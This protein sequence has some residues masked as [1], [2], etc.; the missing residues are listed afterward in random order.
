MKR[1]ADELPPGL[2][3]SLLAS[4][5]TSAPPEASRTAARRAALA[6]L[7]AELPAL[8]ASTAAVRGGAAAKAGGVSAGWKMLALGVVGGAIATGGGM[9]IVGAPDARRVPSA[10][11]TTA[12]PRTASAP[13]VSSRERTEPVALNAPS[14]GASRPGVAGDQPPRLAVPSSEPPRAE[15][16]RTEA[17][18]SASARPV[19]E[20]LLD[21]RET[22]ASETH[23]T[24]ARGAPPRAVAPSADLAAELDALDAVRRALGRNEPRSALRA[25]IE[26]DQ[27]FPSGRLALE[28]TALR[29]E[30]LA[31]SGDRA[32]A[33]Q[34]AERLF[35]EQPNGPYR[36]RLE[37]VLSTP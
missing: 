5:A 35:S 1:L 25:L 6:L 31:R 2:E 22:R 10:P 34:L 9:L 36:R 28:A 14:D 29:V 21:A 17:R 8:A 4:E 30:A 26:Y 27:D 13:L 7:G 19:A 15:T 24:T 20:A 37:K 11:V 18:S 3:L 32:Q 12:L 23:D 16:P 33:R